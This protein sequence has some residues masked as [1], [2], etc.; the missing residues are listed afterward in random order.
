MKQILREVDDETRQ[1]ILGDLRFHLREKAREDKIKFINCFFEEIWP[2]DAKFIDESVLS[3]MI[4]LIT[5]MG[6]V[7]PQSL[8]TVKGFLRPHR[9]DYFLGNLAR[10][11]GEKI[12]IPQK[13][14]E[15][16]LELLDLTIDKDTPPFHGLNEVLHAIKQ[17]KPELESD[18][19]FKKLRNFFS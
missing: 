16:T 19:R 18:H 10:D 9:S 4:S 5:D 15:D 2:L 12:Y 1:S 3:E 13:F 8:Q 6:D 7:F 14:P 11:S 17:S